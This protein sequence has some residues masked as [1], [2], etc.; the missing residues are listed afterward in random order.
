M[1]SNEFDFVELRKNETFG[2]KQY[3]DAIYRG[4]LVKGE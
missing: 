2:V 4:L 1:L 3:K